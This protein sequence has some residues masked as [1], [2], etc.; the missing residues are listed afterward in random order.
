MTFRRRIAGWTVLFL[1]L[2]G[3]GERPTAPR[4]LVRGVVTFRGTPLPS[5]LVVFTPDDDYGSGGLCAT[6]RIGSDGRF[7]LMTD[8]ITGAAAGKYRVTVAGPVGWPLPDK[9]LDP[10]LS[11]LR[12]EVISG[13]E[14]VFEFQL[15]EK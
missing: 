15:Q 10:H 7:T 1:G 6:G 3:C 4:A 14:N 12:A 9:F 2:A 8:R 5:G 13:Q 11:G